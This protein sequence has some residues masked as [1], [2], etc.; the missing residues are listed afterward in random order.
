MGRL[1]P[2]SV[3]PFLSEFAVAVGFV[4][5]RLGGK[6]AASEG[7]AVFGQYGRFGLGQ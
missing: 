3:A 2:F 4:A 5:V 1:D 7:G 6:N